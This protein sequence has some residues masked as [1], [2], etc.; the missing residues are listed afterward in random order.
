MR[1]EFSIRESAPDDLGTIERLYQDAFPDEDLL[2]LVRELLRD[3][4]AVL[5]LVAVIGNSLAGH[6]VFTTCSVG[7]GTARVALLGPLAVAKA[8]QRRGIGRALVEAGMQQ[9]AAAGV[10]RVC[11]LG[12]PAYYGPLGFVPEAEVMPPYPL[13]ARWHAAWQSRRQGDPNPPLQGRLGVPTPWR[14]PRLWAP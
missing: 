10:T 9:S 5:S 7:A 6:I 14:Q 4:P 3:V 12:D 8:W 1:V 2:P 13:P 11:V